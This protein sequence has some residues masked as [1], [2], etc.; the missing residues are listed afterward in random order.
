MWFIVL[1]VT[2]QQYF[3]YIIGVSCPGEETGVPTISTTEDDVEYLRFF[4]DIST[5]EED[6]VE[7]LRFFFG[8]IYT[9]ENDVE[10]LRYFFGDISTSENDVVFFYH[11][12]SLKLVSVS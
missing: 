8:D 7:Y 12:F 10:Y 6:V 9:S 4:S 5:S 3:R 2:F 1:N 11:N